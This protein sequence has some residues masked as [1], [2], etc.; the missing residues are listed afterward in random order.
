MIATTQ[1][2]TM[3]QPTI[4]GRLT[5]DQAHARAAGYIELA[6]AVCRRAILDAVQTKDSL[7]REDAAAFFLSLH[8]RELCELAGFDGELLYTWARDGC[9]EKWGL[10]WGKPQKEGRGRQWQITAYLQRHK[11]GQY[12]RC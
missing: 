4:T 1:R 3:Q 7:L 5:D 10:Q 9:P 6:R 2:I 8:G 12:R 11:S